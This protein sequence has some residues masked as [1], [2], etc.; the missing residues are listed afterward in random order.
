MFEVFNMC[1][2]NANR[3]IRIYGCISLTLVCVILT[4]PLWMCQCIQGAQVC[5]FLLVT[6]S[7]ECISYLCYRAG[8]C[9]IPDIWWVESTLKIQRLK[10][11]RSS[12]SGHVREECE[13]CWACMSPQI[14]ATHHCLSLAHKYRANSQHLSQLVNLYNPEW[15]RRSC[16][17]LFRTYIITLRT[18]HSNM[19][20]NV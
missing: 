16:S 19:D 7:T 6:P 2:Q 12:K 10:A 18:R 8:V 4:L 1:L 9:I 11:C 17:S 3:S 15:W 13:W 14:S 5:C 20:L